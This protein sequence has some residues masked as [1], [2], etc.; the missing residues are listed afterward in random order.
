L[1]VDV[2]RSVRRDV[3]QALEPATLLAREVSRATQARAN[4]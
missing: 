3:P 1:L 4:P 2:E